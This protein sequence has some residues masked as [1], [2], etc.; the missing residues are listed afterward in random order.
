MENSF[1]LL[2]I[3]EFSLKLDN[4]KVIGYSRL[5][6][7]KLSKNGNEK[8]ANKIIQLLESNTPG[9]LMHASTASTKLPFDQESRLQL[10]EIILPDEINE[11]IVLNVSV[12]EY[13]DRFI[14][15][16]Q[17][18]DKLIVEGITPPNT[19]LLYGAPGCGKTLLAK[20]LSK[21]LGLPIV[22]A[23]LDSLIS[24]FLG[25]TAK[26]IRN[27]FEYAKNNQC[28]LFFD[29]FDAVAKH[30][31][32]ANELG[33]LKR[34]VNSLLQNIDSLDNGSILVAATNHEGLLDPA[35]WRRFSL[36]IH[37]EKPDYRSRYTII[38][39]TLKELNEKE[40]NLLASIF[41]E[42]SG[43]AI[44][45]ICINARREAIINDREIK[46]ASEVTEFFFSTVYSLDTLARRKDLSN[47]NLE[48]R[49]DFLRNLDPKI[50]TYSVIAE[51]TGSS[52]A[53]VYRI[54][55]NKEQ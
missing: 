34:V 44:K 13:V 18:R 21:A 43:A 55:N 22:I 2:K 27:Y 51:L 31:D 20:N 45:E 41:R 19:M 36:K 48:D 12:Q 30:R 28:I 35:I 17:K 46:S 39:E 54:C 8:L 9:V 25:N 3:I 1:E 24:S 50:F 11:T 7:D 49:V 29:E 14:T 53:T 33:E 16:Y 6:V 52:K 47:Y 10:G 42:L 5:L 40:V 15:L 23:R 26:N 32:D 37:M 38:S 4:Q